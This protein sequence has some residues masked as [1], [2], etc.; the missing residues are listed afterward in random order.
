MALAKKVT[1]HGQS[2]QRILLHSL[3]VPL[4]VVVP[5][6]LPK[7]NHGSSFDD[8]YPTVMRVLDSESLCSKVRLSALLSPLK[9]QKSAMK[10]TRSS[11]ASGKEVSDHPN[12]A[13]ES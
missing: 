13:C 11:K 4:G 6:Q 8:G 2:A 1:C 5:L 12:R 3:L 9:R 7:T 10:T